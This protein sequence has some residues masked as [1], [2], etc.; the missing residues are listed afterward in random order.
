M[1]PLIIHSPPSI[2]A[3]SAAQRRS[4]L[5]WKLT[6]HREPSPSNSWAGFLDK[7]ARFE[8]TLELSGTFQ[9]EAEVKGTIVSS[10]MLMLGENARV[11]GQIQGNH[12]VIS[13]RFNGVIFAKARVEIH[14]KGIVTGEIHTPCLI[15]EPGGV[16][17]GQC[18]M[19][20]PTESASPVLIPIRA[21][22]QA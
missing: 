17:D 16:F 14:P 9:I 19:A 2:L 5:A 20:A 18:H 11:E 21:V 1:S 13:G 6:R 8:G 3:C 7:A 10:Q 12:V 15:I 22:Q 4:S